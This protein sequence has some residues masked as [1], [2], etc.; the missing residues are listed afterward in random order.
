MIVVFMHMEEPYVI[1]I[2]P[3]GTFI[4]VMRPKRESDHLFQPCLEVKAWSS[5]LKA[6][7]HLRALAQNRLDLYMGVMWLLG[8]LVGIATP[9]MITAGI[10]IG[11]ISSFYDV[12]IDLWI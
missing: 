12:R 1:F 6:P 10:E 2:N 5:T 3:G 9:A 11:V 8:Q 7:I 4:A